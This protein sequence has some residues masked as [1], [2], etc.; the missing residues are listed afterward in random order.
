M[1]DSLRNKSLPEVGVVLEDKEDHTVVK[2]VGKEAALK[3][4]EAAAVVRTQ[5]AI[6]FHVMYWP[7]L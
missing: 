2:V 1:C 6:C 5:L 4:R 7:V 3:E